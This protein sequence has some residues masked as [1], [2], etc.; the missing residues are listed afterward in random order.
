V[1]ALACA[2]ARAGAAETQ[3][4]IDQTYGIGAGSFELGVYVP[5]IEGDFM[6]LAPGS[7]TM[8]GWTVG[9]PGDGIKWLGPQTFGSVDLT[10]RSPSSIFTVIPTVPGYI[11]GF[12]FDLF[13][14]HTGINDRLD[15]WFGNQGFAGATADDQRVVRKGFQVTATSAETLIS[16]IAD[17]PSTDNQGPFIDNVSVTFERVPEPSTPW[18][19]ALGTVGVGLWRAMWKKARER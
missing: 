14:A 5:S 8:T 13:P 2:L 17:Y 16:F 15:F 18:V 4:I 7:T 3:N 1:V 11:Y 19:F 6:R 9:G 10:Y 12:S